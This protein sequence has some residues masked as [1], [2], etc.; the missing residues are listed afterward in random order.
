MDL[1]DNR[2]LDGAHVGGSIDCAERRGGMTD[3]TE[4]EAQLA[5]MPAHGAQKMMAEKAKRI[6]E[7][8]A[9]VKSAYEEGWFDAAYQYQHPKQAAKHFEKYWMTSLALAALNGEKG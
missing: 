9:L 2:H 7:L 4:M 5:D 8:E 1:L 3:I 6:A